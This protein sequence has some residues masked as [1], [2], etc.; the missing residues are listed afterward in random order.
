MAQE[1]SIGLESDQILQRYLARRIYREIELRLVES[2]GTPH[3]GFITGFDERCIQLSTSPVMPQEEPRSILL[4]WPLKRI[5][6]TGLRIDALD[7]E[8]RTKIRAANSVL[9]QECE[10]SL[11]NNGALNGHRSGRSR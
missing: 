9:R 3:V 7:P 8:V 4:F 2:D 1:V 11:R 6:E 5:E 10:A